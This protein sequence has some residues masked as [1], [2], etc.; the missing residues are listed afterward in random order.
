MQTT[1]AT[2][3]CGQHRGHGPARPAKDV[4]GIPDDAPS[5]VADS[6]VDGGHAEARAVKSARA[7]RKSVGGIR[8]P[9]ALVE[10]M[11]LAER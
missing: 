3:N 9:A 10:I 4:A 8:S 6:V 7:L 2:Q 1:T 11:V 5:G